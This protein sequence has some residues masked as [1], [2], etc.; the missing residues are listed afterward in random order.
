MKPI[1]PS[2]PILQEI[3]KKSE[4]LTAPV[5]LKSRILQDLE[6]LPVPELKTY[7]LPGKQVMAGIA[8]ILLVCLV[9]VLFLIPSDQT[10]KSL[11]IASPPSLDRLEHWMNHLGN[12][13]SQLS[14]LQL[15]SSGNWLYFLGGGLLILWFY[16]LLNMVLDRLSPGRRNYPV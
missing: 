11:K 15:S 2:D 4:S 5:E 3:L 6:Q 13:F 16:F 9:W 8:G 7:R 12:V 10:S 14:D 1:S